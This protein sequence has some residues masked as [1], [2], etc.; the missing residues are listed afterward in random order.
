MMDFDTT[1]KMAVY[2]IVAESAR[3]P[4]AGEVAREIGAPLTDVI[5]AFG[6]LHQK[7]LLV[8]EPGDP[9]RV[10]MAPPFSGVETPFLVRANGKGYYAN[11][12]WDALGVAAALHADAV[13]EASDGH[14]GEPMRME[15]RNGAMVRT[16]VRDRTPIPADVRDSG[17]VP[18]D[19][20][21]GGPVPVQIRDGAL[22]PMN[23]HD[24]APVTIEVRDG[25]AVPIEVR[26]ATPVTMEVRDGAALPMGSAPVPM[27][28]VAHF[29]V[30]A[31][32]WWA[33]I[34]FT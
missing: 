3:M 34:I 31:A 1:V 24:E 20:C 4:D 27:Q 25:T 10:R 17:P 14:T 5:A 13:V 21:D 19:V 16:E 6:R 32:R 7:R 11:C 30:P 2:R 8:P 15:V 22:V 33:D 28:G 18:A 9:A 23:T 12:V 29:A 26:R